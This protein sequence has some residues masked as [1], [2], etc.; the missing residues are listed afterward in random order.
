MGQRHE[1]AVLRRDGAE[2]WMSEGD[3]ILVLMGHTHHIQQL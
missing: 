1:E 3:V 2:N